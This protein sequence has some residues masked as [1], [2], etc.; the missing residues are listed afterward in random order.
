[1]RFEI[2]RKTYPFATAP[3]L[4]GHPEAYYYAC[5]APH[6][7]DKLIVSPLKFARAIDAAVE[8]ARMDHERKLSRRCAY[9]GC[10]YGPSGRPRGAMK[11]LAYVSYRP[12]PDRHA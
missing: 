6:D 3:D 12:R 8:A 10:R 2:R 5:L 7:S 9:V 4:T 11:G 1:M